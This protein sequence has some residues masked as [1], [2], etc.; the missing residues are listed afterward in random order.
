MIVL[1]SP[2]QS[3]W[4]HPVGQRH[5][6]TPN[7]K[8][9]FPETDDAAENVSGVNADPHV[10]VG[11]GHL[12]HDPEIGQAVLMMTEI[13]YASPKHVILSIL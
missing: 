4:L 13:K 5:I 10:D 7:V 9:P 1:H 6:V 12:S 8:L 11:V 3:S 2:W